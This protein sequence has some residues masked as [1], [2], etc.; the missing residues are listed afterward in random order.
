MT[1]SNDQIV[2]LTRSVTPVKVSDNTF[3]ATIVTDNAV[4][5]LDPYE[6]VVREILDV[7]GMKVPTTI[8]YRSK[9]PS[10][11]VS[12]PIEDIKGKVINIAEDPEYRETHNLVGVAGR[13]LKGTI[14]MST[15]P[16][17]E[18]LTIKMREKLI[19][20]VSAEYSTY[21]GATEKILPGKKGV[22]RGKEFTNNYKYSILIRKESILTGLAAVDE[23]ADPETRLRQKINDNGGNME[24]TEMEKEKAKRDEEAAMARQ[25][26]EK[27]KLDKELVDNARAAAVKETLDAVTLIDSKR[28]VVEPTKFDMIR[29]KIGT[30]GYTIADLRTDILD[31]VRITNVNIQTRDQSSERGAAIS[32]MI[33]QN[34]NLPVTPEEA[35]M[36]L[37]SVPKSPTL[38]HL[39]GMKIAGTEWHESWAMFIPT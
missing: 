14:E 8:S 38:A 19:G 10:P 22:Y 3:T 16:D 24:L 5:V 27:E 7:D 12:I 18:S 6:G 2:T 1:I 11:G 23:S 15:A 9:H 17:A 25:K 39:W 36:T 13:A 29:K 4:L 21:R 31:N 35:K 26:L 37:C 28:E 20:S 32:A 33:R 34:L 30:P